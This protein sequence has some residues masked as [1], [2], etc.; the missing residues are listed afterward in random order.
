[1]RFLFRDDL[2]GHRSLLGRRFCCPFIHLNIWPKRIWTTY[3]PDSA[4]QIEEYI[5]DF[6]GIA[7]LQQRPAPVAA[8][9]AH[10]FLDRCVKVDHKPPSRERRAILR[11]QHN[12]PTGCKDDIIHLRHFGH[13]LLFA[14]AIYLGYR[15]LLIGARGWLRADEIGEFPGLFAVHAAFGLVVWALFAWRPQKAG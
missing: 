2:A 3:E 5:Q 7:F 15:Q 6:L 4:D 10:L 8:G 12:T 13:D 11:S 1:M 9:A 14:V